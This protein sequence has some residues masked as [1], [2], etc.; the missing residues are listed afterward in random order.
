ETTGERLQQQRDVISRATEALNKLGIVTIDPQ[1]HKPIW[2]VKFKEGQDADAAKM[3]ATSTDDDSWQA[4]LDWVKR[5]LHAA[6]VSRF[7][8]AYS[9]KAVK[10]APAMSVGPEKMVGFTGTLPSGEQ[11]EAAANRAAQLAVSQ[12]NAA[13]AEKRLQLSG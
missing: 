5:N 8:A 10:D 3:M 13:T 6:D 2:D 12:Q 7:A 1:T 11:T 4:H 9:P